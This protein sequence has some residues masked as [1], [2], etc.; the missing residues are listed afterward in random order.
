MKRVCQSRWAFS[1]L[2]RRRSKRAAFYVCRMGGS[3]LG[4]RELHRQ[5]YSEAVLE[6]RVLRKNSSVVLLLDGTVPVDALT[7]KKDAPCFGQAGRARLPKRLQTGS[8]QFR[9]MVA[10]ML[11]GL[12]YSKLSSDLPLGKRRT[13]CNYSEAFVANASTTAIF[14][15]RSDGR[16]C[17]SCK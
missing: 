7:S 5:M 2:I 3:P 4:T 12:L 11:Q 10:S 17:L 9:T 13:K 15:S 1:C 14:C 8:V 6:F 16:P